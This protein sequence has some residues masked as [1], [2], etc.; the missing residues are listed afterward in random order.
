[1]SG[2]EGRGNSSTTQRQVER[3]ADFVA[4]LNLEASFAVVKD[5]YRGEMTTEDVINNAS[6]SLRDD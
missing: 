1:M 6:F 4:Y 3:A 2:T 5:P